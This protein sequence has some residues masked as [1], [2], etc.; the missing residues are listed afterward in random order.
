LFI[1][2]AAIGKNLELGKNNKL[3]WNLPSDLKFFKS[4]TL[5]N[6][7][8][9]GKNTFESLPKALPNRINVVLTND[10]NY[11][12]IDDNVIIE[13]DL[14]EFIKK[15]LDSSQEVY[16]IGGA[17]VYK[18]FLPYCKKMYLTE[19]E[20]SEDRADTY[21]PSFNKEDW[22]STIIDEVNENNITYKHIEYDRKI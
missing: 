7:V 21:F 18:Q 1:I 16:V 17:S 2:I 22:T 13:H 8:I 4:K 15:H 12:T 20:A 6:T 11:K 10:Y 19:I 9:M 14:E 5:G 3:I